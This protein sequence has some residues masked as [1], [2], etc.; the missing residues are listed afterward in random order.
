MVVFVAC[1]IQGATSME[2]F[3]D[4]TRKRRAWWCWFMHKT[5][6]WME[7]LKFARVNLQYVASIVNW[8]TIVIG[9]QWIRRNEVR[10]IFWEVTNVDW[11]H[12]YRVNTVYGT[13]IS[14]SI[15]SLDNSSLQIWKRNMSCFCASCNIVEWYECQFSKWVDRWNQV[16]L[17]SNMSGQRYHPFERGSNGNFYILWRH[18]ICYTRKYKYVK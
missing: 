1:K 2:P 13:Q 5:T 15:R 4:W 3:W 12:T 8:C 14:H 6:L 18:I 10:K 7:Q 9:E 17:G 11:S 16:M